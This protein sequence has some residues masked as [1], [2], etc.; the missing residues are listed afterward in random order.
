M[1]IESLNEFIPSSKDCKALLPVLIDFFRKFEKKYTEQFESLQEN[2]KTSLAERNAEISTLKTEV[3]SLKKRV[4]QLEEKIEDGEAYEKR[5]TLIFSGAKVPV[6]SSNEDCIQVTQNLIRENLKVSVPEN[7]IS[8][9]H[10]L[11]SNVNNQNSNKRSIIVKFC[12][13][14]TKSDVLSSARKMRIENL[15]INECLTSTQRMIGFVL[16][17]AKRDHPDII[18]GSTTFEGKYFVWTKPPNTNSPGARDN[19]HNVGSIYKLEKFLAQNLNK[20]ISHYVP[21]YDQS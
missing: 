10:R 3:S 12:R 20:E 14:N 11:G 19:K 8:V 16:R 2:M 17:K 1:S 6:I 7:E 18:S 9:A 15:Y 13:R 5:D 4:S 21:N